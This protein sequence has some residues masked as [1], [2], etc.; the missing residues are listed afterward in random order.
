MYYWA[1]KM[2]IIKVPI[3]HHDHPA[4][5]HYCCVTGDRNLNC[6]VYT[7]S[8]VADDDANT[9]IYYT[10]II[11]HYAVRIS[12]FTCISTLHAQRAL[13]P[14][15]LCRIFAVS[16]ACPCSQSAWATTASSAPLRDAS[17]SG[18]GPILVTTT[19]DDDKAYIIQISPLQ[20]IR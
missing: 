2:M 19:D 18:A 15:S 5:V 6:A 11:L 8:N 10:F 3:Q 1:T 7:V 20:L 4:R 16:V 17:S 13:S 14:L 12:L 9:Y